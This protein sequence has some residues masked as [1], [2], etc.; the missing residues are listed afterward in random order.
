MENQENQ[1]SAASLLTT[2]IM[3]EDCGEMDFIDIAHEAGNKQGVV[4]DATQQATSFNK[5][6]VMI[7]AKLGSV[8][9]F[10]NACKAVEEQFKWGKAPAGSSPEE[11]KAWEA[12]PKMYQ[13]SKSRLKSAM[14]DGVVPLEEYVIQRKGRDGEV[15][16]ILVVCDTTRK[17]GTVQG[18]LK[19]QKEQETG[20]ASDDTDGV[21]VDKEGKQSK[22]MPVI[23][24]ELTSLL[25]KIN[26][27]YEYLT[28]KQ[29]ESVKKKLN[30]LVALT[31][32]QA[33]KN[34]EEHED[35]AKQA[36]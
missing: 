19:K 9:N 23:D 34:M 24:I 1:P 33:F 21:I 10:I 35:E 12:A 29:Q 5:H 17:M 28:D 27:H 11:R 20:K 30:D 2:K 14:E 22:N 3:T 25:A 6:L 13:Q 32:K 7:A 4:D 36:A 15:K 16:D 18:Y 26:G 8:E 31:E